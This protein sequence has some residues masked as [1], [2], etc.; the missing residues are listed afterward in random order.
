MNFYRADDIMTCLVRDKDNIDWS[1][2]LF[3][4]MGLINTL[5][6][7]NWLN[8][9]PVDQRVEHNKRSNRKY[10]V[11][12]RSQPQHV[13]VQIPG[14][15]QE[16]RKNCEFCLWSK[17]WKDINWI[18]ID[19]RSQLRMSITKFVKIISI[20]SSNQVSNFGLTKNWDRRWNSQF[21]WCLNNTATYWAADNYDWELRRTAA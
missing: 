8:K 16:H 12:D 2:L 4:L 19:R 11:A 5:L 9:V 6:A 10:Y 13:D 17:I 21:L 14:F 20:L 1:I 18:V 3:W 15:L 7:M